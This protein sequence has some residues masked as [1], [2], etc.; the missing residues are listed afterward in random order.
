MSSS[1]ARLVQAIGLL[2]DQTELGLVQKPL[3][4]H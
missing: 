4:N 1:A 2:K 3:E